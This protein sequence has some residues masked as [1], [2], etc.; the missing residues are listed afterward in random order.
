MLRIRENI[1]HLLLERHRFVGKY[2]DNRFF[3]QT[4]MKQ[5][6]IKIQSQ[7]CTTALFCKIYQAKRHANLFFFWKACYLPTEFAC[8]IF[9]ALLYNNKLLL[10][11][12][13]FNIYIYIYIYIY[14]ITCGQNNV[15]V[16][17]CYVR[18]EEKD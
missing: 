7:L 1:L 15:H 4:I 16:E 9:S 5:T 8:E 11:A 6:I 14:I 2:F 12:M 3:K 17:T 18:L 10:T 13:H